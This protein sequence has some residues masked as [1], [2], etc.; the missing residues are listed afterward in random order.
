MQEYIIDFP[1]QLKDALTIVKSNTLS[2]RTEPISNIVISGLGGSG[3]L[4]DCLFDLCVDTVTVPIL[5]NKGYTLPK[6]CD[7]K[8]LLILV[9]YSGNTEETLSCFHEAVALHL[10]PICV[11]SGGKLK[12][13]ALANG[14]DH[15]IMPPGFPPR[16][17]LAFGVTNL[18][19]ILNH[20]GMYTIDVQDTFSKLSH[21]LL[22]SQTD[23]KAQTKNFALHFK[24]K[25][26]V[27]YAEDK[28]DSIALRLKQQINENSKAFCWYNIIPELNHNEVVGWKQG[29]HEIGSLFIRTSFENVR[30]KHRFDFLKPLL[31]NYV[32]EVLEIRAE[33]V[34]FFEQYFYLI[35]W[36]DWLSYYLALEHEQDP[37]EVRVIDNLKAY[38]NNI[39]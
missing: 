39:N 14:F 6:F 29:H 34:T 17:S 21:F 28:I 5:A 32:N 27:A 3:F 8:T 25:I 31:S 9:S 16:A 19:Y 37:T 33:G 30:N 4:A 18:F 11:S 13:Y 7:E 36:C 35:H 26:L 38:L 20:F 15:V 22:A 1:K 12:D 10:K 2:A 23:I 24:N